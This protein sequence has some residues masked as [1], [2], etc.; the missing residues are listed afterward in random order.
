MAKVLVAWGLFAGVAVAQ[1]NLQ[2]QSYTPTT[3][4]EQSAPKAVPRTATPPKTVSPA[5]KAPVAQTPAVPQK[6]T[7][8]KNQPK[9]PKNSMNDDQ[10][11]YAIEGAEHYV[12]IYSNYL[13]QPT[14]NVA[15]MEASL[16]RGV[17][18]F[19]VVPQEN[20]RDGAS[21][22][23]RMAIGTFQGSPMA[24]F[25]SKVNNWQNTESF[26]VI[27]GKYAIQG[28]LI[29]ERNS[30]FH[31]PKAVLITDRKQ[32]RTYNDWLIKAIKGRAPIQP[33]PGK[34]G[35]IMCFARED[36]PGCKDR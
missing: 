25:P 35:F 19:V 33:K 3:P 20:F 15:L 7:V 31:N 9:N 27:D 16:Q 24:V 18:V 21:N 6:L 2:P 22:F 34:P 26:M 23:I 12:L 36:A 32:I 30:L 4:Q 29:G 13:R 17:Y 14:I 8:P 11:A 5:P 1:F 10:V 28:N